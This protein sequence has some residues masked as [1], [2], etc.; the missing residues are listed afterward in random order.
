MIVP[1]DQLMYADSGSTNAQRWAQIG[2]SLRA[3]AAEWKSSDVENDKTRAESY[4]SI[5]TEYL[6]N[7][8]NLKMPVDMEDEPQIG[9]R[10]FGVIDVI[11]TA[12]VLFVPP[13][14][15][16]TLVLRAPRRILREGSM[17]N[18]RKLFSVNLGTKSKEKKSKGGEQ[19]SFKNDGTTPSEKDDASRRMNSSQSTGDLISSESLHGPGAPFQNTRSSRR[20]SLRIGNLSSD[21]LSEARG[22]S[23]L[24]ASLH[25]LKNTS[26]NVPPSKQHPGAENS[27]LVK[28]QLPP[29]KLRLIYNRPKTA[30]PNQVL[31]PRVQT[32]TT[33]NELGMEPPP[34][35]RRR[36]SQR[37][38]GSVA[39]PSI[40]SAIQPTTRRSL[41]NSNKKSEA[42]RDETP[43]EALI[44]VQ[45]TKEGRGREQTRK[46]VSKNYQQDSSEVGETAISGRSSVVR[47]ARKDI[48]L[49]NQVK[50]ALSE[51]EDTAISGRSSIVRSARK[52]AILGDHSKTTRTLTPKATQEANKENGPSGIR[53]RKHSNFAT[54]FDD[55]SDDRVT[56]ANVKRSKSV[57]QK[58]TV[59]T[60]FPGRVA[61]Q[62]NYDGSKEEGSR[63][64]PNPLSHKKGIVSSAQSPASL[65]DENIPELAPSQ[66]SST[67]RESEVY[68]ING[69]YVKEGEWAPWKPPPLNDDSTLTFGTERYHRVN[70]KIDT[71]TELPCRKG[72]SHLITQEREALFATTGV[73]MAT[74]FVVDPSM[75]WWWYADEEAGG[76]EQD[77]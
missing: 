5:M 75:S 3:E 25:P 64:T 31:P 49:G 61:F 69:A 74:R 42:V 6:E 40:Q 59:A 46:I 22:N 35:K 68:Y 19:A 56:P 60:G 73:L 10:K 33:S 24:G 20:D 67:P 54:G 12:G 51:V 37:G 2:E 45:A 15:L 7:L 30:T 17:G 47:S 52:G 77:E 58:P 62:G 29:Q 57:T 8:S 11:I 66:S 76:M 23:S 1:R 48:I 4:K 50:T 70:Y 72:E 9:S 38:G 34:S 65:K 32:L 63:G 28:F 55:Q 39:K 36:Q 26:K 18:D 27:R 43:A 21:Q 53:K 14:S 44:T 71:T 41:R 16:T 13:K